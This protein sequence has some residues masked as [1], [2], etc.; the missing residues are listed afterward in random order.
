LDAAGGNS[1]LQITNYK[2]FPMTKVQTVTFGFGDWT[3]EF[4]WDLEL[5]I[6]NLRAAAT[7]QS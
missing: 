1:K 2:Q 6:W 7:G 4:V 5:V 3:L